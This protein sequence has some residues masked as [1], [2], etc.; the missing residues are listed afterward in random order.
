MNTKHCTRTPVSMGTYAAAATALGALS[1]AVSADT[2]KGDPISVFPL[3]VDSTDINGV[4]F[5][6]NGDGQDDARVLY[7]ASYGGGFALMPL[8]RSDAVNEVVGYFP[9]LSQ[10]ITSFF[11]P[12]TPRFEPTEWVDQSTSY[13]NFACYCGVLLDASSGIG[14]HPFVDRPGFVA[15]RLQPVS[16]GMGTPAKQLAYL[17]I[18]VSDDGQELLVLSGGFDASG[19]SAIRMPSTVTP[20]PAP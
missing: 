19:S 3:L 13:I 8:D 9:N 15:M 6:I 10:Q 5:D 2:L 17:E 16:G 1:S 12:F 7:L 14:Y 20:P 18:V 4:D 11:R